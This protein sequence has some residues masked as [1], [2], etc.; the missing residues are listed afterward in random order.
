MGT[1]HYWL[2]N[3]KYNLVEV[4]L[5]NSSA[6]SVLLRRP[7]SIAIMEIALL[8]NAFKSIIV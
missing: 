1:P 3:F 6:S 8:P 5:V 4:T 7:N 2:H